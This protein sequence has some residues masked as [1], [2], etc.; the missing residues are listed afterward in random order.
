[1]GTINAAFTLVFHLLKMHGSLVMLPDTPT[2]F[3]DDYG[4]V[5]YLLFL[6][7]ITSSM[8]TLTTI[9]FS[10]L[11]NWT[12]S[13]TPTISHETRALKSSSDRTPHLY[14]IHTTLSV[15]CLSP[16][17]HEVHKI[18]TTLDP[19]NKIVQIWN[20]YYSQ[21]TQWSL[22]HHTLLTHTLISG[23]LKY[24]VLMCNMYDK[25][26]ILFPNWS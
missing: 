26:I 9:T 5:R 21:V 4:N 25:T 6:E 10:Q 2:V 12:F 15:A 8:D 17:C 16:L 20:P 3:I 24:F 7:A 19:I 14:L 11:G 23:C 1:M 18:G 22:S 13:F